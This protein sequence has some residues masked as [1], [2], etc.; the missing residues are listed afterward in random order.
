MLPLHMQ[1][2]PLPQFNCHWCYKTEE[3][4]R[5]ISNFSHEVISHKNSQSGSQDAETQ[6]LTLKHWRPSIWCWSWHFGIWGW[7]VVS[8]TYINDCNIDSQLWTSWLWYLPGKTGLLW[9]HSCLYACQEEYFFN[10]ISILISYFWWGLWNTTDVISNINCS[11]WGLLRLNL[12]L[13]VN[14]ASHTYTLQRIA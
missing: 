1:K 7:A 11:V 2:H 6:W 14:S 12:L 5:K 10:Y 8:Q 4:F 13:W 9:L 3:S